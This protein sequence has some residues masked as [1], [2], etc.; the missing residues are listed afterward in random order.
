MKTIGINELIEQ[1]KGPIW[2]LNSS[3]EIYQ[4]GADVFVTFTN[5]GQSQIMSIPRTWLPVEI[6]QRFPRKV[7]VESP[8]FI[9]AISKG[10]LK[11]I[12]E[13]TAKKM[14]GQPGAE[15][16]KSR[17]KDIEEAVKAATAARGIGKNV[18]IST[19]DLDR[20]EELQNQFAKNTKEA[21]NSFIKASS[22]A[23]DSPGSINFGEDEEE[24]DP[25]SPNFKAWVNKV[26]TIDDA[27]E[28]FGEV[29]M[30]GSMEMVEAEYLMKNCVHNKISQTIAAR[31]KKL[32]G[33]EA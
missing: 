15:K 7:V 6:T 27:D 19:G 2:V 23:M 24:V 17:L 28:A 1:E 9:D 20:D 14:M 31:M 25:V 4:T 5:N 29:R 8:Y 21:T 18:M 26:N 10:L 33:A 13:A 11:V 3:N 16:E 22:G 32:Q 30:R 12:D